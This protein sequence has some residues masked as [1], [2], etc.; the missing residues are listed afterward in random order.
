[1]VSDHARRGLVLSVR[2]GDD[3]AVTHVDEILRWLPGAGAA[4][5]PWQVTGRWRAEIHRR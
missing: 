5:A 2:D 4:L 3:G 1:V